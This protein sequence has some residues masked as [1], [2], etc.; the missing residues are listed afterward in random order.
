LLAY[1]AGTF[2]SV[3]RSFGLTSHRL[4]SCDAAGSHCGDIKEGYRIS[5]LAFS[6]YEIFDSK[7]WL[8]RL[9]ATYFH[10]VYGWVTPLAECQW[11][12]EHACRVGLESGDT[13]FAGA[14]AVVSFFNRFESS[15]LQDIAVELDTMVEVMSLYRQ[16]N[17]ILV[18]ASARQ[19]INNLMESREG[20]PCILE[21]KFFDKAMSQV[22]SVRLWARLHEGQLKVIFCRYSEIELH[23]K[24]ARQLFALSFG[25][26][27]RSFAIFVCGLLDV[28][29]ACQ[30]RRRRAPFARTCSRMLRRY[31]TWGEPL[32]FIGKHYFLE[33]EL[34]A[35]SR[36]AS[37]ALALYVTAIST[38]K[39][40]NKFLQTALANERAA[41]FL[42]RQD[43]RRRAEGF[44]REAVVWYK[45]GG[46]TAKVC[47]LEKEMA[48]LGI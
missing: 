43:D 34:A 1:F 11:P 17:G 35:L 9:S 40:G 29:S 6:L 45:N 10:L 15:R 44:F 7:A 23:P 20:N 37:D 47:H 16:Q 14:C 8:A 46:V 38:A 24:E 41:R 19:L 18:T 36:N 27:S 28:V 21:G 25:P 4:D 30:R 22:V 2:E 5:Q 26:C 42:M 33:A 31:A 12:L 32:D 13:E 39:T 3:S 48:K